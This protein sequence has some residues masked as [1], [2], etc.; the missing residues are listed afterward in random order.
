M[1]EAKLDE[2]NLQVC[3]GSLSLRRDEITRQIDWYEKTIPR[4]ISEVRR[5]KAE[6]ETL[7]EELKDKQS[8]LD[9]IDWTSQI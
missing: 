2:W 7:K 6:N 3:E 4:L 1:D 5:L 8:I 9:E